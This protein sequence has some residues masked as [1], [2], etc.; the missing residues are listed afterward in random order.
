M[1][2]HYLILA[3]RNFRRYKSSFI[4][5][6]F[7]LSMGLAVTLLIYLWVNDE[8]QVNKFHEKSSQLYQVMEHQQYA[9]NIMTTNSTPGIIS[10]ELKENYPEVVYAAGTS[11]INDYTLTFEETNVTAEGYHVGADFFNIFS[12]GLVQGDPD[13]VLSEKYAVVISEELATS[14]FGTTTDVIGKTI[15][16]EHSDNL[17][18]SGVFKGTP[19]NSSY[20]F[21]FVMTFEFFLENNEWATTWGS[22]GP[23]S[24]V[25]LQEGTDPA[26]FNSKIASIINDH[27]E[28][29]NVTV[30]VVPYVNRY[31]YGHFDNGQPA[32]G[33]IDTIKLFSVI[34]VFILLIACI[35]FMNL[36]TA[37]ASRRAKEVGLKKAIGAQKRSLITQYLGESML[38]SLISLFVAFA[39]VWMFLP[40]FNEITSKQIEL[41]ISGNLVLIGLIIMLITGLIAGSYP[42]LY[43][44]RFQ[45]V[46]V[47]KGEIRGSIGELWARRGLVIFQFTLSIILIVSVLVI[48][49]QI[50]F[51][52]NKNLGYNKDNLIYFE[53]TGEV[54]KHLESF[55][56]ELNNVTGVEIA[57]SMAHSMLSRNNNSSGVK[58][59]G[60]NPDDKILFEC[61]RV[62]YDML[63]TLGVEMVEGRT[64]SR[65]FGT[66]STKIIFNEAAIK[67]MNMEEPIGQVINLW[68]RYDLEIIGVVK[69]FHFQSLHSSIKPLF[70]LLSPE[71]NWKVTARIDNENIPAT[72]AAI[73]DLHDRFNPGFEFNYRFQDERYARL[74]AS[75]QQIS[76]LSRYFAGIAILISSLGLF[77]L[78]AFTAERR[79]KEI[80]IRKALG[81]T[82][83]GIVYLLSKDF[84]QMVI[85]AILIGTPASYYLL[86]SYLEGYAYRIDLN[87]WF[88]I[89]A[90]IISLL[91]ALLTVGYQAFK[92]ASTNPANCLREE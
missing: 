9:D 81:S 49:K 54:E 7:G 6:L 16:L 77:G 15:E 38:I 36:S 17:I 53:A 64:F 91:I 67:V 78:A 44:S 92:S 68:S 11:W 42:A 27:K 29:N 56:V 10:N 85:V 5:N 1:F 76:K 69:D 55:L 62:N 43:L 4:I 18:I 51:V 86:K 3:L 52:Q 73:K 20:Q 79:N 45:A 65:D 48:Y 72:I 25:I 32:G 90:G 83:A 40:V 13:Q 14:L 75:E 46:S 47:L 63:E 28:Q 39:M 30:F 80:G 37:R 26:I 24:Y 21:D 23:S 57:S 59:E 60:K 2:R 66:D 34:A 70:F 84:T 61:V 88:F 22:N 19:R 50:D 58:W 33:R 87:I 71:H 12:Y 74:Y 41:Q 35:N 82:A 89:V 8:L 31:L